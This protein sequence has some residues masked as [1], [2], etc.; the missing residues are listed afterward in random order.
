MDVVTGGRRDRP[1]GEGER[2]DTAHETI[3]AGASEETVQLL[4]PE[5]DES[6]PEITIVIPA[7]NEEG[8]IE[9]FVSWCKEGIR[10]AGLPAEIL[11]VDSSTDRTGEL[12]LASGARVL[13]A[14]RRGLGRAYP[15]AIPFV[16]GRYVLMGDADCTYDF[17]ELIPFVERFR[18]GYEFIMGSRFR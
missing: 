17:R 12:A 8:T 11:I 6:N 9:E 7:L 2:P 18:E 5:E 4:V 13:K 1:P 14:P 16:R 3:S 15:D 10:K